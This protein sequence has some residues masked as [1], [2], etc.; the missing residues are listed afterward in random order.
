MVTNW[1]GFAPATNTAAG[2]IAALNFQPLTN[3][4][5]SV[6]NLLTSGAVVGALGFQPLTNNLPSVTN[7]LTSTAVV[8]ALGFQP[9]TNSLAAITNLLTA[10]A[11]V[12]ELGYTPATNGILPDLVT[13]YTTGIGI[14]FTNLALGSSP[15][16]ALP[17]GSIILGTNGNA[18]VRTNGAW[19]NLK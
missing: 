19:V 5:A 2:L 9:A 13:N 4:L 12:G 6:T 16:H 17:N 15:A 14:A 10:T 7:L 18:Y 8:G 1:L 3:N 11:I